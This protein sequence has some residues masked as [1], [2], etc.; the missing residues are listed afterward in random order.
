MTDEVL[1]HPVQHSLTGA[2]RALALAEGR[3]MRYPADVSPFMALPG[4]ATADD[5]KH[6]AHLAEPDP[7]TL[8]DV[9]ATVPA[10][11]TSPRRFTVVQMT[12][13]RV[14]TTAG[15]GQ[16]LAPLIL[17]PADIND[18]VDLTARTNPGPFGRR[19]HEM[20][21]YLGFRQEGKLIAMAGERLRPE[22]WTEISAVCTDPAFRGRG[23]ARGLMT[24]LI[25]I[26]R[27]RGEQPF[28]HVVENAPA[29]RLYESMGFSARR[30]FLVTSLKSA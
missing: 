10:T 8:L 24:L 27:D 22:G 7:I 13:R 28:L 6:L 9:P 1:D 3:A 14:R 5:W 16:A 30:T 17:G 21:T 15:R 12:G 11:W 18:M 23:L 25:E 26:I 29:A 4:D 19:T 2:H 20:G